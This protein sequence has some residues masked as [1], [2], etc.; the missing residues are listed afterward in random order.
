MPPT[1]RMPSAVSRLASG[2]LLDSSIA[3]IRFRRRQLAEALQ[4][5]DVWHPEVI[6]VGRVGQQTRGD[7]LPDPLLA[8]AL[9]VHGTAG[10][11]VHD[12]LHPLGG[13]V[14]V[15]A[16]GVALALEPDERG[17]AARAGAREAPRLAAD[18]SG[19]EH[20][21]DDLGD[22]VAGLAHDDGVSG[23]DVLQADLVLVVQAGEPDDRAG[24]AARAAASRT[25]SL[26]RFARSRR[27][28]PRAA[29]SAPR[30]GTCRRPPTGAR[31][32]WP[33]AERGGRAPP[34]SRRPRRSRSRARD[35][36]TRGPGSRRRPP[37]GRRRPSSRG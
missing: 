5:F 1:W 3:A 16:I 13:A 23:T 18:R 25:A 33:R 19:A 8:E 2:R 26:A 12:P 7:E 28:C 20:R 32:R 34:P 29:S 27:G 15:D 4:A 35:G 37:R 24:D 36:A 21:A 10:G 30:A 14:A 6:A 22:H 31:A 17:P 11:E 9:D